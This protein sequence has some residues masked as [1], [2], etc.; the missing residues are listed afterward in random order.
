MPA[1]S[2]NLAPIVR[3]SL[4]VI[5]DE[6]GAPVVLIGT[7]EITC[8]THD[9]IQVFKQFD[10]IQLADGSCMGVASLLGKTAADLGICRLCRNPPYTFPS[11]RKTIHGLVR[12]DRA[13]TCSCGAVICTR[14]AKL[15]SDGQWRC[16]PCARR[17]SFSDL[18]LG[19]FFTRR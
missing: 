14:H 5:R 13:H 18:L 6:D 1:P 10:T 12:L 16:I 8:Q 15:G 9:E 4:N 19:L 17:R 7:H 11:R 2:H 3:R